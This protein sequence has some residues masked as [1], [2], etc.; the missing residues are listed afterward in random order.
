[1]NCR[2]ATCARAIAGVVGIAL[3]LGEAHDAI[4]R[5]DGR[6]RPVAVQAN[7]AAGWSP[8][9]FGG[10]RE[11]I[12][13]AL[14]LESYLAWSAQDLARTDDLIRLTVKVDDRP[15]AFW[16]QGARIMAYDMPHWI[17]AAEPLRKEFERERIGSALRFLEQGLRRHPACADLM[18]E[19]GNLQL[20]RRHDLEAA[21]A[22]YR[23]AA[24]THGAPGYA[25]RVYAG[26][27]ER[28]ANANEAVSSRGMRRG[29]I[30]G[31]GT[32]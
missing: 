15:L 30:D 31:R 13:D 6:E 24:A 4:A 16:I 29:E 14:W 22:W 20:Y 27:A 23:Q 26:L 32:P 11:L 28:M 7:L 18:V 1:V 21:A 10:S 5:L 8:A 19:I 17:C 2:S 12:A 9:V 25:A 3:G